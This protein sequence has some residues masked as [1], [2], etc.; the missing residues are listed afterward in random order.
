[1]RRLHLRGFP[2]RVASLALL[3]LISCGP[4]PAIQR[5]AEPSGAT[6]SAVPKGTLKIAWFF[7]PENLHPKFLTGSGVSEYHWVFDS[8]LFYL[9]FNGVPHPMLA[10]DIPTQANGGWIVNPDGTMVTTYR[11]RESARWHDGVP[12]TAADFVFAYE[13][14]LD[15][16]TPIVSRT[17]ENLMGKVEAQDDRTIV[18]TWK[19]P[20][21]QA[22]VLGYRQLNPLPSHS[23]QEKFRTNK[24]NFAFGDE[25]TASYVGSGPFR[26]ERWTPGASL[27]ARAHTGW[28]LGPPRLETIDIRF[29]KDPST[30]LANL[31]S[32]EIDMSNSSTLRS[33][34]AVIARDQ[35]ASRGAGW[36]KTWE[37][38]LSYVEYQYRDFPN[39]QRAIADLRVRQ[40]LTHAID[41][42]ALAAVSTDGLGSAADVFFSPADPL[43]NDVHQA[44]TKY[45]Y[46]L[47]RA[48]ALLA[49]AG[50]RRQA[51]GNLLANDAGQAMDIEVWATPNQ[52]RE[53]T[54]VADNWRTAGLNTSIYIIP[55]G[56]ER[57]GELRTGFPAAG[58]NGRSISPENFS[59]TRADFATPQNRFVGLNRGSFYDPEVDRSHS[60]IMTSFDAEERRQAAISLHRR[61]S[62]LAGFTPLF[63]QV[64]VIVAKN[65]VKGPVGNYGPQQGMTWNVFEWEIAD[66]SGSPG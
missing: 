45:P 32:G 55:P 33:A 60:A 9:D 39:W 5:G 31:L 61:M 35:W 51:P 38:R 15:A 23:L 8:T 10:S 42:P 6:G 43:F 64:E 46:D 44:A 63:Y 47:N 53:A 22:N 2:L 57:E 19:E 18:V 13:V 3:L 12:I 49:E 14:Y 17:P 11:L 4:A 50:W 36:V 1:L 7:E 52:T 58:L 62:E 16:D 29:V 26:V 21:N 48:E 65:T 54:V 28:V 34:E 40:A 27:V 20:Y 30:I 24:A 66:P 37:T 25:W 59:F 56:R 41:R